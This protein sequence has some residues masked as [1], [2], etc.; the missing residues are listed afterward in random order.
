MLGT[1]SWALFIPVIW[2]MLIP[3]IILLYYRNIALMWLKILIYGC[4]G[5]ISPWLP[6]QI[7][8]KYLFVHLHLVWYG[9]VK[10]NNY[11]LS[12]VNLSTSNEIWKIGAGGVCGLFMLAGSTPFKQSKTCN[13]NSMNSSGSKDFSPNF[14]WYKLANDWCHSKKNRLICP[15]KDNISLQLFDYNIHTSV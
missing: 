11:T 14:R 9:W 15:K 1:C 8:N 3:L 7:F 2:I 12:P 5:T 4:L 10:M 6:L 13:V